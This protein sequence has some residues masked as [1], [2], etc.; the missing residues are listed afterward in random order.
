MGLPRFHFT[1][2]TGGHLT[3][4]VSYPG[5]TSA[6]DAAALYQV[7]REFA[8]WRRND[9]H[10]A[11]SEY[12]VGELIEAI[13]VALA[14]TESNSQAWDKAVGDVNFWIH[15]LHGV[16]LVSRCELFYEFV[17]KQL[18]HLVARGVLG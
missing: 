13:D 1:R 17:G 9:F 10:C 16:A 2:R 18:E 8:F 12:G 7:R 4:I 5:S 6:R 14:T 3:S 15:M 11:S